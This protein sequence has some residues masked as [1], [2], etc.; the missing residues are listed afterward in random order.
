MDEKEVEIKQNSQN[1]QN[2]IQNSQNIQQDAQTEP[3]EKE[4]CQIKIF[5]YLTPSDEDP[6]SFNYLINEIN[7]NNENNI[8]KDNQED[9]KYAICI[10]LKDNSCRNCVLLEETLKGIITQN[11]GGL[12]TLQI[13]PKNI[14][15][16]VF[17]NQIIIP[18]GDIE[19]DNLYLVK[20]ESFKKITDQNTFIKIPQI[21]K[22]ENREI[23]IDVICKKNYMS[24]VESL[25]CYYNYILYNLKKGEKPI[26]SSVITAGVLPNNDCL[27]KLIQISFHSNSKN[28]NNKNKGNYSIVVPALEVNDNKNIFIKIAQYER[29]HFNIYNMAF[30]S[31]TAA[32]PISS[33]LNTMII[34][35]TLMGS[36]KIF[37]ENLKEDA[38]IDYHDYSLGLYLYREL[39]T[40]DYYCSELLGCIIYYNDFNYDDYKD[41]WVNKFSGYYGNFFNICKT[42]IY[43]NG[44]SIVQK[45]FMLFQIIGL[46]IEFV[47]P[48]LS[49]L[50]IYS[51]FYEAFCIVDIRPAAFMTLLYITLYLGSGACSMITTNSKRMKFINL[52]FFIFMEIYY[53]FIIVCS[54]PAM[55]N[56]KKTKPYKPYNL[57]TINS[58]LYKFNAGACACLIIFT[59]IIALIPIILKMSFVS[60]YIVQMFLYLFLGAPSS[61]SNFLIAKIWKAPQTSGG[62]YMELQGINIIF[63]FLFN[64]F[65]GFLSFYN[66]NRKLR[67]NCVMGLAIFYLIY[68]FFKIISI[69]FPL[70]GGSQIITDKDNKIIA[71]LS[72]EEVVNSIN[73]NMNENPLAKSTDRLKNSQNKEDNEEKLDGSNHEDNNDYKQD[74]NKENSIDYNNDDN[75]GD[76][77][78]DN[79]NNNMNGNDHNN[80]SN[81]NNNNNGINDNNNENQGTT[82]QNNDDNIGNNNSQNFEIEE[83]RDDIEQRG[84]GN[85]DIPDS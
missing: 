50:V 84:E 5:D 55:D 37:Y 8:F 10:L 23:K 52:F 19:N 38:T 68:L 69:L 9:Y 32:V 16:F 64:L 15:I 61:T 85:D 60:K 59:F 12:A 21:I 51:I 41:S 29:I 4:E 80:D 78:K 35:K 57:F 62:D 75:H 1:D 17:V 48:S 82:N 53:L 24:D 43:C 18:F 81:D 54:I 44:L 39:F 25:K 22:D 83:N 34:G 33:L 45:I 2:D 28:R 67:A 49:I 58:L 76:E 3:G 11:L 40:I 30:Y 6:I 71:V 72:G 66:Y 36:L 26:I 74:N 13:D 27:K 77:N 79:D 47:Y 42:F 46:L 31:G 63:F 20:K 7:D 70:L 56:I 73:C 14:Y 65:I